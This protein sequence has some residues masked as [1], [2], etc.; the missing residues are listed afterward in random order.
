M[1]VFW[2][3]IVFI[4]SMQVCLAQLVT[5][6]FNKSVNQ[7][8]GCWQLHNMTITTKNSINS[9]SN[10]KALAG[11][12]V[13]GNPAY[14][15][16]SPFLNFYGSG[17]ITFRHK[18]DYNDGN[19][20][21]LQ[22]QLL[23]GS[24]NLVNTIYRHVYIDSATGNRP[25]GTPTQVMQPNIAIN[26]TGN[27][28]LRFYVISD[29]GT[30]LLRLDDIR[31]DAFDISSAAYNNGAGFCRA[32]DTIHDTICA[33]GAQSLNLP[34]AVGG[35]TWAWNFNGPAGGTIDTTLVSGEEDTLAAISWNVTA[36]GDYEILV[37]QYDPSIGL[38]SYSVHFLINVRSA[39]GFTWTVD[40]VC[41][42]FSHTATLQ[43]GGGAGPWLVTFED[44][45]STF[46]Q[47]FSNDHSIYSLGIYD[48][49]RTLH[50]RS[51]I[52]DQGCEADTSGLNRLFWVHGKPVIGPIW[53]T[54]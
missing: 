9:G 33:G 29:G 32:A 10:K 21:E 42:G 47:S 7:I 35:S 49:P 3:T 50:V 34:I 5:Q 28:F 51:V 37:N 48:S 25:N 27:Y 43:F 6:D 23:D 11:T 1:K 46:S 26:W 41:Q 17:S 24:E 16:T 22:I 13:N 45:D 53:H 52:D 19:H 40:S 31:I 12:V 15:F 39:P 36:N 14:Y 38:T 30:S 20:R 4:L 8:G 2:V 44:D 18:L 54:K